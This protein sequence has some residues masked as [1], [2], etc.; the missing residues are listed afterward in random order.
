MKNYCKLFSLASL[1]LFFAF[2]ASAQTAKAKSTTKKPSSSKSKTVAKKPAAPVVIKEVT[3][4]LYNE[5]EGTVSV[6]AGHKED[7][8]QPKLTILGGKSNN[9]LYLHTNDVVCIISKGKAVACVGIKS[10][11]TS[12]SINASGNGIAEK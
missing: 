9:K 11:T 3:V 12:L 2:N 4:N 10:S 7:L 6:F 8:A 1:L 5:G